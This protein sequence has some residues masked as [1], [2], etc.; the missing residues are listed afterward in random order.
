M[1]LNYQATYWVINWDENVF[2]FH[3]IPIHKKY[4]LAANPILK[5][6]YNKNHG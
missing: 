5:Y 6:L 2:S 3:F 4:N 1:L